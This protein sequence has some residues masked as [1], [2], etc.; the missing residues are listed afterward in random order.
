MLETNDNKYYTLSEFYK[1]FADVTRLK[2]LMLLIK[3]RMNVSDIS[4][5]LGMTHSS[6]SHQLKNLRQLNMV[7]AEKIGKEVF[8]SLADSHI[9]IILKFGLEHINE[10]DN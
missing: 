6:I 4:N 3:E 5:K 2:M 8:Y 7:K 9:E 10:K 1:I